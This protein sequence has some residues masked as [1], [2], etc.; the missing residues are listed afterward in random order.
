MPAQAP[1][2]ADQINPT[3][4]TNVVEITPEALRPQ[5]TVRRFEFADL[6]RHGGWLMKRLTRQYPHMPEQVLAAFL[7]SMLSNNEFS[8]ICQD[9]AVGLAQLVHPGG[10]VGGPIIREEFCWAQNPSEKI[11]VAAAAEFYAEWR[12]WGTTM[13]VDVI[14]VLENSDVPADMIEKH[15]GAL[16]KKPQTFARIGK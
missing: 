13:G 15:L 5:N 6:S 16:R 14:V 9:H 8:F 4:R 11:H 7:R 1:L 2:A 3:L 10:L 12:R